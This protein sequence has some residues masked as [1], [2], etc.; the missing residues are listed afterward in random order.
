MTGSGSLG[1]DTGLNKFTDVFLKILTYVNRVRQMFA[2]ETFAFPARNELRGSAR[3]QHILNLMFKSPL[4]CSNRGSRLAALLMIVGFCMSGGLVH[5]AAQESA[6]AVIIF[7]QAQDMHEKG[8]L[9][10][11][12]SL[13]E[14]ALTVLPDFPEAVFQ[15]ASAHLALGNMDEAEKGFRRAVE[16]RA[17]WS[18]P[19]ANLGS[20]LVEKDNLA[21][22]EKILL[23]ALQIE[24]NDPIA[25]AGLAD[26]R[27]R[28]GASPDVLKE[29][30]AR[31]TV[32]TLKANPAVSLWTA[33]AALESGLGTRGPAKA[34]LAKAL[35]ADPA[36]RT[37]ILM[38]AGTALAEGDTVRAGALAAR[39]GPNSSDASNM[40]RA[41]I[42]AQEGR[43]EEAI[44][45]LDAVKRPTA[46]GAALRKR[47]DASRAVTPAELEKQL[48]A[49]A[50][51]PFILGR[52]CS[53]YRRDEPER[54]LVFCR[55]AS[56]AEPDNVNHAIGFGAA[57]VQA[58]QYEA[59]IGLFTKLLTVVPDN[60]TAHANL[61]T[62][63]FQL[64]RYAEAKKEFRWLTDAQPRSPA[65]YYFLA[66]AHDQLSEY[67]D[68]GANYQQ[69][70]RL[71]DPVENKLEIEK[72]HLRL[73]I[74]Q[75][76]I[77]KR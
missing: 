19:L 10:G 30:L 4:S 48:E 62:A 60:A 71:A 53:L 20:L 6:N 2:V 11:A 37:A 36:N 72:V 73:P 50:K 39:L 9:A 42:S 34:S 59:A 45:F 76:L 49:D 58:K 68:A 3:I 63:L 18:L 14:K 43:Y 17:D 51:N 26:L 56:E 55:R 22:A 54:A 70:L 32:L 44:K 29:L 5:L 75:K 33:R 57:L 61:G 40:L 1:R 7:N 41:T 74:L 21:E 65:A 38:M 35:E 77:K 12:I 8:D 16:L 13:Y 15:R 47:I 64:K 31:I 52:L 46:R 24:P 67:L 28:T 25:L 23:K 27:L 66:L 69:Y